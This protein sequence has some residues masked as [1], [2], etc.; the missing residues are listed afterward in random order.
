MGR[1]TALMV[2]WWSSGALGDSARV[3][4]TLSIRAKRL[5]GLRVSNGAHPEMTLRARSE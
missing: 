3:L 5:R 4:S 1:N 2:L